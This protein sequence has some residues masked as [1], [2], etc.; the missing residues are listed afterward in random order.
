MILTECYWWTRHQDSLGRWKSEDR[1][2]PRSSEGG[3]AAEA[4]PAPSAA[5]AKSLQSCPTLCNPIDGSP[6]GSPIPGVLP[7]FTLNLHPTSCSLPL[8]GK[9]FSA[10]SPLI[11]EI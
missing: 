4:Y 2:R 9:L 6:P 8:E 7:L 1:P 3:T 11:L 10:P 5:A